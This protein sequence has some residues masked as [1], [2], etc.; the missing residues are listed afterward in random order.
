MDWS[1]F[2]MLTDYWAEHPPVHLMVAGYLG[3]KPAKKK[4]EPSEDFVQILSAM[5][6]WSKRMH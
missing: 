1:E 5:P 2:E 3:I 6:G 4:A